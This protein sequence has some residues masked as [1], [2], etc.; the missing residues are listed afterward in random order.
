MHKSLY[1]TKKTIKYLG[2]FKKSILNQKE[3]AK[4]FIRLIIKKHKELDSQ[5]VVMT[6]W[7]Y[8][9]LKNEFSKEFKI[10]NIRNIELIEAFRQLVLDKEIE[11]DRYIEKLISRRKVR[12]E[13]GVAVI[14][15][16]TKPFACPGRCV[17]CPTEPNMPKSY[18][19]NQPA[20]MR[21]VLNKFDPFNQTQNRLASLM[22]TGHDPSKCEIIVIGG[23]WSF[24]PLDY[25]KEFIKS[26][27]DGLNQEIDHKEI[28]T[29]GSFFKCPKIERRENSKDLKSAIEKNE[30]SKHRCVGLTLETRPD[31]ITEE[32]V[33][34]FREYGCTRVELGVQT[35]F[36]DVQEITKRGHTRKDTA[37]A[38][39]LLRDA[40]F[41]IGW[42]LM[43]GLPGSNSKKDMETVRMTFE[44]E[45]FKPDLIKFYPCVVT[46]YSEL[47]KIYKDGNFTPLTTKEL[48]PILLNMK[49]LVPRFCRIIRLVRDIPKESII[50]GCTVI[51][52]RQ[53]IQKDLEEQNIKC[54]C[55]R[56]REIKSERINDVE[57]IR[58]NYRANGG[59]EIFLTFDEKKKDK[60][61]S[62]LRLRI[63]SQY[64]TKEKHFIK[65]LG[66]CAIIREIHTYGQ[67]TVIG[68][69][70]GNSQHFG[71]GRK[72]IVEAER[73]AKE[74]YN[75][76]K[77]AVISGIG[78]REYY[79]KF[80]YELEGTYMVK[81]L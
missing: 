34:R 56:C 2:T 62:L 21:A 6:E 45:D 40:G 50:A 81:E 55:I 24:L 49:K 51:N 39:Q 61:I 19:S 77:I 66:G 11:K 17:Y 8:A 10:P 64:F 18:L 52:L 73:I 78:T 46:P 76:K 16:Q 80:G 48:V 60:L 72:L 74:E 33:K 54:N 35:L 15:C 22:V 37:R 12:S 63:P 44:D 79:R 57:M 69:R 29:Y 36:D 23:T 71:F 3:L 43:P 53:I 68:E 5:Q 59:D 47:E 13:S 4:E 65:E 38:T 67:Q 20:S 75:L 31:F 70:D 14:T 9:K 27:Y 1:S 58:T 42:H 26:I 28:E 25:Q 41:K 30:K 32:E 7:N